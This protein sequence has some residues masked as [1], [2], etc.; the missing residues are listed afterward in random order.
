[1]RVGWKTSDDVA[2]PFGLQIEL[3]EDQLAVDIPGA[4]EALQRLRAMGIAL[5]IDDFGTGY[6]SLTYLRRMPVTTLKIDASFVRGIEADGD[7]RQIVEAIIG[8]AK[9]FG[10]VALAE[11]I[12][13]EAALQTLIALGC[14]YGQGYLFER[15]LSQS[16]FE[17]RFFG[18]DA[19]PQAQ[20]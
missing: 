5:A 7:A 9:K 14:D 16:A 19:A 18:C 10:F 8:L 17:A 11:G 1:M 2:P 13:S 3:T 6:S 15:P 4:M 20:P 12:E